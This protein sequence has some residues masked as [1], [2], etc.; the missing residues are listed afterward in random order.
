MKTQSKLKGKKILVTGGA[1]FIG[2]HLVRKLLEIKAKVTVVDIK[3]NPLSIFKL[4]ELHKRVNL[5]LVDITDK[6]RIF[7]VFL[8]YKPDL[9][10][11]LAAHAIVPSALYSPYDV[12]KTNVLGTVNILEAVRRNQF[13]K[14]LI[15]ASSDK[16]YGK[17]NQ[18]KSRLTR[19]KYQETDS[20]KGDHPYDVSKACGD[21]IC[22]SYFKT[23]NIPVVITRF[24]NVCGEGDFHFNRIVPGICQAL[25]KKKVLEIRSNGRYVRDYLYIDDVVSGYLMLA[26]NFNNVK[27]E[28]FNFGSKE[29]LSVIELI[30]LV[31]KSLKTKVDFKILNTAQNEIPYQSLDYSKVKKALGWQPKY[32]ILQTIKQIIQWYKKASDI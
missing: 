25:V 13:V 30:K 8:K 5:E 17:L 28:A 23:F 32:S 21:L 10:F 27:G 1:G 16:A 20:L 19:D 14:G 7:K 12:I 15:A 26:E 18:E 31:E 24:G 6:E 4:H 29:T 3:I 2:S 9:V 22:Q 11:H